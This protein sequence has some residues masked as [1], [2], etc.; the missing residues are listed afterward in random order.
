LPPVVA[1]THSLSR[2][3][4]PRILAPAFVAV[5]L[6]FGAWTL[7]HFGF[8]S[9]DHVIDT[10]VYQHY[11]DEIWH[12]KVPYRDF[13][14]EYPPGALPMF[15]LPGLAKPAKGQVVSSEF[16][17][18]FETTMWLCGVAVLFA[19]AIAL[20]A[21]RADRRHLWAALGFAALAPLAIGSVILSRFDLWPVA[22]VAAAL[23]ALLSGRLRLGNGLLGL[24]I[25]VKIFPAVLV[26]L[27]ITYAWRRQGRREALVCAGIVCAAVAAVFAPFVA[28][29]PGGVWHS[30]T[31]QLTRPLQIESLGSALLIAAHH[32]WGYEITMASSH[33]SQNLVGH[34]PDVAAAV[35]SVV[36]VVALLAVW[37]AFA[38]GPATRERLVLASGAAIAAFI[39]LSKV[40]S[41]QFLIWLIPVVPL[42]RGR[43]GL[44]SSGLLGLSLVLTQ[45]WFPFRYWKLVNDFEPAASWLVLSRDVAL[46]G[47]FTVLLL[48]LVHERGDARELVA[49]EARPAQR[50]RLVEG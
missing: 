44:W 50:T 35:L 32:A 38:R 27:G 36:Q 30:L 15:A 46:L 17:A 5:V 19:T 2:S 33:G 1:E 43:R 20:R 8:Y 10:P 16:K 7:L 37:A 49:D 12:G 6:F 39:G 41:P 47:L 23:A 24:G 4:A 28:I 34:A 26:P 21:L 40:L 9:H 25:A 11:G 22:F 13:A 45:V 29:A 3:D 18:A 14:V 48:P 31:G 42:V